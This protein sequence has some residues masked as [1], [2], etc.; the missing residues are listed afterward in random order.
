MLCLETWCGALQA[1]LPSYKFGTLQVFSK[2]GGNCLGFITKPCLESF[3][4]AT[5]AYITLRGMQAH[6]ALLLKHAYLPSRYLALYV[7]SHR[8][9]SPSFPFKDCLDQDQAGLLGALHGAERID[10]VYDGDTDFDVAKAS[11]ATKGLVAHS[12]FEHTLRV[13][14]SRSDSRAVLAPRELD[15]WGFNFHIKHLVFH[16]SAATIGD[17]WAFPALKSLRMSFP[18][19]VQLIDFLSL[20]RTCKLLTELA[21]TF[22]GLSS[23]LVGIS[24][25]SN[26]ER[27]DVTA[28]SGCGAVSVPCEVGNLSKLTMLC[29]YGQQVVGMIPSELGQLRRLNVLVFRRTNL[30][31]KP[32]QSGG[33]VSIKVISVKVVLFKNVKFIRLSSCLMKQ[34]D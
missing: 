24:K 14:I 4:N 2:L 19:T 29:V 10:V 13:C 9:T 28:E 5:T 6:A 32:L 12:E 8:V 17:L 7:G 27:L 30:T 1:R 18:C 3:Q 15:L 21:I 22:D 20:S 34:T 33:R 23:S 25:L 31:G 11:L 26:L 16:N